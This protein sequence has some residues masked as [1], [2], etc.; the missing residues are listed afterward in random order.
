MPG[1]VASSARGCSEG[2][3]QSWGSQLRLGAVFQAQVALGR[4]RFLEALGFTAAD[5]LKASRRESLSS[6][7]SFKGFAH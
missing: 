7:P 3:G 6:P 1:L 2:V 4:I 5:F